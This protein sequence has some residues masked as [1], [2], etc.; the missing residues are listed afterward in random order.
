MPIVERW[1][2]QAALEVQ[3]YVRLVAAT[4]R[5]TFTPPVYRRDIVEQFELRAVL[6]GLAARVACQK[7]TDSVLA[8]TTTMRDAKCHAAYTSP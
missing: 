8:E 7:F 2:K 5:G 4:F 3:E 6:E 1:L